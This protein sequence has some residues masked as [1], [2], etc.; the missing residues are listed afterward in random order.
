MTEPSP[1]RELIRRTAMVRRFVEE[2]TDLSRLWGATFDL[3]ARPP[4]KDND[5]TFQVTHRAG[6][7][8]FAL[9]QYAFARE[10]VLAI[11]RVTDPATQS[12]KENLSIP[13]I[14][15]LPEVVSAGNAKSQLEGLWVSAQHHRKSIVG[16]RNTVLAHLDAPLGID[17]TFDRSADVR[18]ID[19]AVSACERFAEILG[20]IY[21][22]SVPD[23]STIATDDP[24]GVRA[25]LA[26]LNASDPGPQKHW[27]KD[28][29]RE[30]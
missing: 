1:D 28:G 18:V 9:V 25:L 16:H 10:V 30:D 15:A 11:C 27:T 6:A 8:F 20:P 26:A 12:G 22:I 14:L 3:F 19:A 13:R 7:G 21:G 29:I 2:V 4:L 23:L 17:P 24:R 5:E